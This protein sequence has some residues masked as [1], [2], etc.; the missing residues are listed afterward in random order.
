MDSGLFPSATLAE[1]YRFAVL[2]TGHPGCAQKLMA[3]L[4]V[5]CERRLGDIRNPRHRALWFAARLRQQCL[6][7]QPLAPRPPRLVRTEPDS[8]GMP[9]V[10]PIEAYIVAQHF[11]GLPEPERSSLALFYLDLFTPEQIAQTL[12]LNLKALGRAL[13]R[14]RRLLE[15]SLWAPAQNP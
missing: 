4:L 5:G 9:A 12:D 2:L 15:A 13:E 14:A 11:H 7:N 6:E 3:D 1:F 10:L 8:Q